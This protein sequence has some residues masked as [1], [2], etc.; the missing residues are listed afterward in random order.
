N[1]A[2]VGDYRDLDTGELSCHRELTTEL[3]T[4]WAWT[5]V[6][7]VELGQTGNSDAERGVTAVPTGVVIT[8]IIPAIGPRV[9]GVD[10]RPGL[11][12]CNQHHRVGPASG[13]RHS[14]R[15]GRPVAGSVTC[16][17]DV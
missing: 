14:G 7:L 2:I 17:H 9:I 3:G 13:D 10:P 5:D 16:P 15:A 12:L 6:G 4:Q 8:P 1:D 11:S